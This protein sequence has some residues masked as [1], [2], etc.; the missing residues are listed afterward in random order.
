M[1][2]TDFLNKILIIIVLYK[3]CIEQSIA[4]QSIEAATVISKASPLIFIYDNSPNSSIINNPNIIYRHHPENKGVSRA[5][6]DAFYIAEEH[7]KNWMLLLD[8]DSEI[9]FSTIAAYAATVSNNPNL[10]LFAP[11]MMDTIGIVSPFRF[12]DGRGRRVKKITSGIY[13]IQDFNIINSGMLIS[14]EAFKKSG[15]YDERFPLDLS[16]IVFLK[17][18]Q[19]CYSKFYLIDAIC[20]HHL[21]YQNNRPDEALTRF[22]IFCEAM[23]QYKMANKETTW[24]QTILISRAIKLFFRH[25]RF[26]FFKIALNNKM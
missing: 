4:F 15:G 20:T 6:N 12:R 24:L 17:R 16:D 5:Y 11:I 7:N 9:K 23:K 19:I 18:F 10:H 13:S 26:D 25:R 3:K 8:Q 1:T 21:S 22:K 14:C 2:Q